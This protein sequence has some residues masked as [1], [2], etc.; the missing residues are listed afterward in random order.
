MFSSSLGPSPL[1]LDER[2]R[3]RINYLKSKGMLDKP[4]TSL[5]NPSSSVVI[6][7]AG[8]ASKS[9][10]LS[11]HPYTPTP[12]PFAPFAHI[13]T[14]SPSLHSSPAP[15]GTQTAVLPIPPNFSASVC[16]IPTPSPSIPVSP[17]PP[18]SPHFNPTPSPSVRSTP[19][20]TPSSPTP[21][22][23]L[24]SLSFSSAFW[25]RV[26][27][28]QPCLTTPAQPRPTTTDPCRT[29]TAQQRAAKASRPVESPRPKSAASSG[30]VFEPVRVQINQVKL[31]GV[32]NSPIHFE[33]FPC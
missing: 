8:L 26:V 33:Y 27:S 23:S 13:S 22:P 25:R 21:A 17:N 28:P 10:S 5:L 4:A 1:D 14:P 20:Q 24:G 7:D 16:N 3:N 6:S 11:E 2:E 29:T 19:A 31:A 18:P 32:Y 30:P 12:P 9:P 15:P